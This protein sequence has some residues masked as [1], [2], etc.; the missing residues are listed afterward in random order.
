MADKLSPTPPPKPNPGQSNRAF[1]AQWKRWANKKTSNGLSQK[2]VW[3]KHIGEIKEGIKSRSTLTPD[4]QAE[5]NKARA[6][7]ASKPGYDSAGNPLSEKEKLKIKQRKDLEQG[8][9]LG[10]LR[11][12]GYNDDD[13]ITTL[14]I[15]DMSPEMQKSYERNRGNPKFNEEMDIYRDKK[16][17]GEL[18]D[19][20]RIRILNKNK[21]LLQISQL[22]KMR[23][24]FGPVVNTGRNALAIIKGGITAYK[25]LSGFK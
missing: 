14:A 13:A 25:T 21:D 11:E 12:K 7:N 23:R 22:E 4:Q 18:T 20:D 2:E 17:K 1:N 8:I 10:E 5:S 24:V 6:K 16:D 15:E 3:D 19:E 9:D